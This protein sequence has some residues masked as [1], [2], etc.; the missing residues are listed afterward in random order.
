MGLEWILINSYLKFAGQ[1][2]K[3]GAFVIAAIFYS[4]YAVIFGILSNTATFTW[5]ERTYDN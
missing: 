3:L 4:F 1:K 2:I 5:K